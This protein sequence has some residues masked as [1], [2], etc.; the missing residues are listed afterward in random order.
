[1]IK[2][3]VAIVFSVLLFVICMCLFFPFPNNTMY[4]ARS[5]FMSFPLTNQDGYNLLGVVG[6]IVFVIAIILLYRGL[7]KYHFLTIVVAVIMYSLLP[8]FLI[9]IYQETFA[10]GIH[11]ISY[12]GRGNCNFKY[13]SNQLLDGECSLV[14][15]NRSNRAVTFELEFLDSNYIEEDI[16]LESL[17]N[18]DGPYKITIQAN[19]SKSFHVKEQIKVIDDEIHFQEGSSNL[20]H[21]KLIGKKSARIL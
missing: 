16:Q 17:M 21:V 5:T 3:K 15:Q 18:I 12:D 19:Q 9:T 2:S 1:M 20:I 11:S 10:N 8:T 14:L 13:E 4:E 6:S 7:K